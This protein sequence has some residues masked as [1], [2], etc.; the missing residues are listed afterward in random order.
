MLIATNI[1]M[2]R[3]DQLQQLHLRTT[4]ARYNFDIQIKEEQG[5]Q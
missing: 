1:L 3:V 2:A 5:T 4:V